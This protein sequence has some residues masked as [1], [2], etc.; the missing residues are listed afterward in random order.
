MEA[1]KTREFLHHSLGI[2]P[3]NQ[4]LLHPNS[5]SHSTKKRRLRKIVPANISVDSKEPSFFIT[6][7]GLPSYPFLGHPHKMNGAKTLQNRAVSVGR[8]GES[9]A[10]TL[11]KS[12]SQIKSNTSGNSLIKIQENTLKNTDSNQ[13]FDKRNEKKGVG[14]KHLPNL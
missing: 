13:F 10:H 8:K 2:R 14:N 6:E 5:R 4:K 3:V 1:K 7:R 11:G 9:Y 12:I